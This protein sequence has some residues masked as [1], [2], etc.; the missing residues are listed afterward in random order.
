MFTSFE[1]IAKQCVMNG[2]PLTFSNN[3]IKSLAHNKYV[4][5][6]YI[7]STL[8][9]KCALLPALII[10]VSFTAYHF[11][12]TIIS[13]P[14]TI[15][16]NR[17]D[18][19]KN[20][21]TLIRDFQG[22]TGIFLTVFFDEI[23]TKLLSSSSG[24]ITFY[25]VYCRYKKE[26]KSF[27][28]SSRYTPTSN[29]YTP[30]SYSSSNSTSSSNYHSSS[31]SNT[32]PSYGSSYYADPTNSHGSWS[33]NYT[34]PSY[35]SSSRANFN[36]FFDSSTRA[37]GFNFFDTTSGSNNPLDPDFN[38]FKTSTFP[39]ANP[40]NTNWR[41]TTY[42][43]PDNSTRPSYS[44]PKFNIPFFNVQ[45]KKETTPWVCPPEIKEL[46]GEPIEQIKLILKTSHENKH[47]SSLKDG[48]Y[49]KE[50]AKTIL[51][52]M[53]N[54][55]EN[56]TESDI[57]KECNKLRLK[58]HPDKTNLPLSE[59]ACSILNAMKDYYFKGE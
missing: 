28:S 57:K 19:K 9:K 44:Q 58:L 36:N 8:V 32:R 15:I 10:K 38:P 25:N 50:N 47:L 14:F 12:R 53:L 29:T 59:E 37:K 6:R 51:L 33:S 52:K 2:K 1:A 30:R 21:F 40:S 11:L 43:K 27:P 13:F 39:N 16:K 23:G 35:G 46:T 5:C 34:R 54:L 55:P 7:I 26:L 4:P 41:S 48:K 49:T 18:I 42:S 45:I 31:A 20:I 56:S 17:L 24:H 3:D 22:I